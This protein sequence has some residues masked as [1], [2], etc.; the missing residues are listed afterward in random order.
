[1]KTSLSKLIKG[2]RT[3]AIWDR[4]HAAELHCKREHKRSLPSVQDQQL[5]VQNNTLCKWKGAGMNELPPAKK[6]GKEEREEKR[7]TAICIVNQKE[8]PM[9]NGRRHNHDALKESIR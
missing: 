7:T 9:R 1:V 5:L 2:S 3:L 6:K 8:E 4:S